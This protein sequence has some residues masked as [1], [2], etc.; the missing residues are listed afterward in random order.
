MFHRT[1]SVI[2]AFAALCFS[3]GCVPKG[4]HHALKSANGGSASIMANGGVPSISYVYQQAPTGFT[5]YIKCVYGNPADA[6][7][8]TTVWQRG[9]TASGPWAPSATTY[10]SFSTLYAVGTNSTGYRDYWAK[11]KANIAG[12]T[13]PPTTAVRVFTNYITVLTIPAYQ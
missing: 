10:Y 5:G 12:D 7:A 3:A 11:F 6:T 1:L 4:G 13:A 9:N 2:A 8:H